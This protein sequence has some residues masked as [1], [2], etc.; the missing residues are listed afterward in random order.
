MVIDNRN[1]LFARVNKVSIGNKQTEQS[2]KGVH[3][4][5]T[6]TSSI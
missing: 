5:V 2:D 3:Y 1:N 6:E 4:R